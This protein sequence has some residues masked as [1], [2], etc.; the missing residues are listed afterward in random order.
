MTRLYIVINI[1]VYNYVNIR[2]EKIITFNTMSK[3]VLITTTLTIT[4]LTINI[5]EK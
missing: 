1:I 5:T 3:S 2:E 4:V